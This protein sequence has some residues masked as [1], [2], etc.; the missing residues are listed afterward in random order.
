M[1]IDTYV[2]KGATRLDFL[3]HRIARYS[4]G[5]REQGAVCDGHLAGLSASRAWTRRRVSGRKILFPQSALVGPREATSVGDLTGALTSDSRPSIAALTRDGERKASDSVMRIERSVF[6]SRAPAVESFGHA[7]SRRWWSG[8]TGR[9]GQLAG[10]GEA[11]D[12]SFRGLQDPARLPIGDCAPFTPR[13]LRSLG[14]RL[15]VPA[16]INRS[17]IMELVV[18]VQALNVAGAAH[19]LARLACTA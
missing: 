3:D 8:F 2:E 4:R 13:S 6:F 9:C 5:L 12:S 11:C 15:R 1:P 16:E 19:R 14:V 10:G 17:T 7:I 18:S